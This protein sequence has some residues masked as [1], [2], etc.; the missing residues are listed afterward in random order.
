MVRIFLFTLITCLTCT[1]PY[2]FLFL[3]S[4]SYLTTKKYLIWMDLMDLNTIGEIW[5]R[6]NCI[7]PDEIPVV[8]VLLDDV[9]SVAEEIFHFIKD[10]SNVFISVLDIHLLPFLRIFCQKKYTFPLDSASIY[11]SSSASQLFSVN[12]IQV[13]KWPTSLPDLNPMEILWG[14]LVREIYASIFILQINLKLQL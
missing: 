10:N 12:H 14:M 3:L 9:L 13:L 4:R 2:I 6:K 1:K 8:V 7:S 5:G 11:T